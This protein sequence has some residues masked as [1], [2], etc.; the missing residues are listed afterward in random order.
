MTALE[1]AAKRQ[2]SGFVLH[3]D[4]ENHIDINQRKT[5]DKA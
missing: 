3:Y 4:R 5:A 1:N 2:I